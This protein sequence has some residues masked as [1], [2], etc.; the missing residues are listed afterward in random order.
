MPRPHL[1]HGLGTRLMNHSEA[2]YMAN[3]LPETSVIGGL[4][5]IYPSPS[6]RGMLYIH[7]IY[8]LTMV[9]I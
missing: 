2:V 6:A 8:R 1:S 4:Q 3:I 7:H 5:K 9:Y